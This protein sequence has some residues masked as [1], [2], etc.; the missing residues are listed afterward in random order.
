MVLD[1]Y[2]LKEQPFGVTPDIR[3]LYPSATH[4]EALGSLSYGIRT[5]R[6][7]MSIIAQPGMG[8]TILLFQLLH[9]LQHSAR[10]VF[11]FQTLCG[12]KDL[13]RSILRDLGVEAP[14]EDFAKMYS[15]L[16][17]C[18]YAEYRG[19]KQLV[20]VIDEAQ[21]LSDPTLELLRMLSNF[22]KP[23]EKLMQIIL[24][25]QPQLARK[26]AS[27]HLVQLRQRISIVARLK[28]FT[29]QESNLYVGHRLRVA[30]YDF[31][32]ALFN[33]RAEALIA[34][35]CEGIPRNL[36]NLCFNALS[37]GYALKKKPIDEEVIRE[38]I[39]DLELGSINEVA[40]TIRKPRTP[41]RKAST[42]ATNAG[43]RAHGMAWLSK[44]A[45]A[46]IAGAAIIVLTIS[47]PLGGERNTKA[48]VSQT[49]MAAAMNTAQSS[50]P[51]GS[52]SADESESPGPATA[53][54]NSPRPQLPV[55]ENNLSKPAVGSQALARAPRYGKTNPR[56][57]KTMATESDPVEL[58]K[59]IRDDSTSAELALASL[60]LDGTVV[61]QNCPQARVLLSVASKKGYKAAESLLAKYR[62]RCG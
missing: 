59:Q 6:G 31:G 8:K 57:A 50:S 56:G 34:E 4:R 42:A 46:V 3:Y 54:E 53:T 35:H 45:A 61:P 33:R 58:W 5:G 52:V 10:T 15:Q 26:L 9:H 22:E 24:A 17:E 36:N 27:P 40:T 7:F 11:L 55:L 39:D 14:G 41:V 37:L 12:P 49:S 19:G 43:T 18:L 25:G 2:N 21:N 38:V 16:N 1:Y 23:R 44:F 62:K 20:V 32:H 29:L 51:G 30:G 13:L 28:P 47:W 48:P 60:Y